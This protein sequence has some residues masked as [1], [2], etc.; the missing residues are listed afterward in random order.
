MLVAP[1]LDGQ[2]ANAFAGGLREQEAELLAQLEMLNDRLGQ[3]E[4]ADSTHPL[5]HL[6][7]AMG[8]AARPAVLPFTAQTSGAD[9]QD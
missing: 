4:R 9:R 5:R 8:V 6:P 7:L 1:S 3:W 2:P